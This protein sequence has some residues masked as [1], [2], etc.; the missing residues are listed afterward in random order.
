[1][2]THF[3][4]AEAWLRSQPPA[5]SGAGGHKTTLRVATLL[6]IGFALSEVEVSALLAVFSASCAPPWNDRELQHKVDEAFKVTP[7]FVVGF[8][9]APERPAVRR[10]VPVTSSVRRIAISALR[11]SGPA[12]PTI[13]AAVRIAPDEPQAASAPTGKA[14]ATEVKQPLT[15]IG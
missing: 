6:R 7:R 15:Q 8:M 2:K 9:L 13:L 4:Q 1:M 3:E 5:V 11:R 14:D 12:A 10:V